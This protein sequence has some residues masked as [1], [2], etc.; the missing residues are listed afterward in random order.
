MDTRLSMK[1]I[2]MKEGDNW[3]NQ[4]MGTAVSKICWDV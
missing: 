3:E 1:G 4:K 2:H